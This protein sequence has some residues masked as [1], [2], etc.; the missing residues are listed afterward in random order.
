M[1]AQIRMS[2]QASDNVDAG[3]Y[4]WDLETNTLYA[5]SAVAQLFGLDPAE[6]VNGLPIQAYLERVHPDDRSALAGDI[7]VAITSGEPFQAFYRV[8]SASGGVTPI[9]AFGKCFSDQTNNPK[10][11]SGIVLPMPEEMPVNNDLRWL[12]LAALEA[13]KREGRPDVASNLRDA[14][15]KLGC[16]AQTPRGT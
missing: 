3:I 4:T 13:A 5:D 1:S 10:I 8:I 9:H 11:Y 2:P 14:L 7:S 12:C 16:L 6:T 15:A